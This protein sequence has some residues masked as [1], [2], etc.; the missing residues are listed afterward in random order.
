MGDR[1]FFLS[2]WFYTVHTPIEAPERLVDRYRQKRPGVKHTNPTYAAMVNRMDHNVGRVLAKLE[3]LGLADRT[4]V[5]L[6]SDN[7]GV[8]IETRTGTPTNNDPLRSGKG[9]LYEGGIRVPLTVRWP[10][11]TK[12]GE[13]SQ[14]VSSQ[15][16]FPTFVEYLREGQWTSYQ[17]ADTVDGINLLPLISD[18]SKQLARSELHWHFP[19]YYPRMTPGSAIRSGDWK[20]IHY[21]E[22]DALELY[23][24]RTDP[25][26]R[27]DRAG[28]E[29]T[30]ANELRQSLDQWLQSVKANQPGR[31]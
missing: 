24:L 9:T 26:E 16:F 13:C 27:N 5:V 29:P 12:P 4:I 3:E 15:D 23:N 8:D 22:E 18:P 25:G 2:L 20:A 19:H 6:T 10:G 1:P 14:P 31:K 21:Y 11:R 17:V 30:I 28:A 7:G